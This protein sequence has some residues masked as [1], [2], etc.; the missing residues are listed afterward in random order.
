[1]QRVPGGRWTRAVVGRALRL[2]LLAA[3][4]LLASPAAARA[5]ELPAGWDQGLFEVRVARNPPVVAVVVL[6]GSGAALLPVLPILDA[7]GLRHSV[8][9]DTSRVTLDVLDTEEDAVLDLRARTLRMRGR[10][11]AIAAD[12]LVRFGGET[13]LGSTHLAR[14][15]ESTVDVDMGNLTVLLVR[16]PPFPAEQRTEIERRR[17]AL[18]RTRAE[19]K[20]RERVPFRPLTGLGVVDWAFSSPRLPEVE[21][22]S[23][24]LNAGAAVWG[25]ALTAGAGLTASPPGGGGPLGDDW[26]ASYR[27][28]FPTSPW[29]RQLQLGDVLGGAG[30]LRAFRGVSVTNAEYRPQADFG[31][32]LVSPPV[33]PGWEYEV[34]QGDR[35][36]GFSEAG[37]RG[38]ISVPLQYGTTL[39]EVRMYGP[40]G[41]EVV[42]EQR[43]QTPVTQLR[44]GRAE[45]GLG[46]GVCP[47]A[48]CDAYGF[49]NLRYGVA[50]WLTVEAG[51]SVTA[52]SA[53]SQAQPQAAAAMST[54]TGWSGEVRHVQA[55]LT[56][57]TVR[58]FGGGP[59]WF[60][61]N[62]G[63][64]QPGSGLPTLARRGASR[65]DADVSWGIQTR[66]VPG[67]LRS[68]RWGVRL[69]GP[70]EGGI[71]RRQV[72]AS[73]PL[74]RG[75][76]EAIYESNAFQQGDL[77]NLRGTVVTPER[78]P[79]AIRGN[80]VAARVALGQA[81]LQQAELSTSLRVGRSSEVGASVV[82][83]QAQQAPTY[84]IGYS[85]RR[86]FGRL[87]ARTQSS[88][89]GQPVT[90][91]AADGSV[92]WGRHVGARPVTGYGTGSSGVVGWVFRDLDGN[93]VLSSGDEPVAG[94]P[95]LVG[96]SRAV[97]EPDGRYATWE[98]PAYEVVPVRVDTLKLPDPGWIPVRPEVRAR[99]TPHV[100]TRIDVPLVETRELSG[101][102][103]AG[104]GVLTVGGVTLELREVGTGQTT[105][106]STFT[107]GEFYVSRIRPGR[108]ELRVSG[109]SLT[110][111]RARAEPEVLTFDV[112]AGGSVP[113]VDLP[114]IRV[115]RTAR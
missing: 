12:E 44:P 94:V 67:L 73:L 54:L 43:L 29:V 10:T 106:V 46:G 92:V 81:G 19:E 104:P 86:P 35:L 36:L 115:V 80:P 74:P 56:R 26:T 11:T 22:S 45:Y 15:L 50:R 28:V 82:W 111:L 88:A 33:P 2:V 113:V 47:R 103:V 79:R 61:L 1:M 112:P 107:D 27:R 49:G 85:T 72:S 64:S 108:Y 14:L 105:T 87:Q 25:G 58:Y 70:R 75:Y 69:E 91:V 16:T 21:H 4:G 5:Q 110:A 23:L 17:Q 32:V 40:A 109:S 18:L 76:A 41:E 48:E 96:G 83:S 51:S 13:Y 57:G 8:A 77:L 78:W 114:P 24:R 53:G 84:S 98:V 55:S 34:F 3:A 37:S 100:F 39:L 42:T 95:V 52:D 31:S 59:A 65:W 102:L 101:Q 63:V 7:T 97:T 6:N 30:Q 93:G 60:V 62:G 71:D 89:G 68:I 66:A 90:S 99:T 20:V 38:P 9:A